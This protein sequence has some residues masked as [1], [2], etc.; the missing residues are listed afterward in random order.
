MIVYVMT[1]DRYQKIIP[2]FMHQWEKYWGTDTQVIVCGFSPPPFELPDFATFFSIGPQAAYPFGR[3]SDA[4]IR[5]LNAFP[6]EKH[7]VL[8]LEDYLLT[9]PVRRDIVHMAHDYMRQFDYVL[10]FD[11]CADRRFSGYATD[12]GLLGDVPIVKSDPNSPYHSSLYL[13]MWNRE[14]MLKYLL[15]PNESPHDIEITGTARLAGYGD[16]VVV[17]GTVT[18][19]WPVKITLGFR[20]QNPDGWELQGLSDEDIAEL[21]KRGLVP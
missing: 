5:V 18:D 3:W 4:L 20:A 9:Q 14:L 11:L 15:V 17:V 7:F 8:A 10:K 2:A 1:S 21:K 12:Y 13:G 16:E 19:P 6:K